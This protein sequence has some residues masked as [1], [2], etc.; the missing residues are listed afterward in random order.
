[1]GILNVQRN[2]AGTA[3]RTMVDGGWVVEDVEMDTVSFGG[4]AVSNCNGCCGIGR[5]RLYY[6]RIVGIC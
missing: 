6:H 4:V 1:M 2:R 5:C 3:T